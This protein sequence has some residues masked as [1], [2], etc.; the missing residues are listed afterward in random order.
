MSD[1]N[2]IK[3]TLSPLESDINEML[4]K[5]TASASH[6]LD[7][8]E[9][10][11]P[12]P[13]FGN[14]TLSPIATV[15][16]NPSNREFVD[17]SGHELSSNSRRF[18]T[19]SSLNL[20]SWK[21][22]S[23]TQ[24]KLIKESCT[25]YFS[26]NPYDGWFKS[27][28]KL[29]AGTNSSFYSPLFHASHLDLI[30][31]A[32]SNKWAKLSTK[33]RQLLLQLSGNFLAKTI[34]H[35]EIKLLVLNGSTVVE[36]FSTMTNVKF[37]KNPLEKWNLPRKNG[38]PILGISYQG[39]I[40]KISGVDLERKVMVIGYNHNIQSSFGVTS[41]VRSEIQAWITEVARELRI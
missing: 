16:L 26:R 34:K 12:I 6:E 9:W 30:P 11:S 29:L 40:S 22:V 28:D 41:E 39:E 33:Q 13:Y 3:K 35:S 25:E 18:H 10:A 20:A 5:I 31:F 21:D 14:P 8:I 37:N 7:I 15:G 2:S 24:I 32:T 19:L 1:Y 36:N 4:E 27:L 38:K 23:P 17:A